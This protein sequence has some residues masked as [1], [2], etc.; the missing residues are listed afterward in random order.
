MYGI[1]I[2]ESDYNTITNC[3][4]SGND[5]L[6][7]AI[8]ENSDYNCGTQDNLD[9]SANQITNQDTVLIEFVDGIIKVT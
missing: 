4:A 5:Y 3:I 7:I 2:G 1:G 6:G 9:W 8:I